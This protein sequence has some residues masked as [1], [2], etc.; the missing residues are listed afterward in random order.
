[1]L[2][3]SKLLFETNN[4]QKGR[5]DAT[6]LLEGGGNNKVLEKL[7]YNKSKNIKTTLFSIGMM[8]S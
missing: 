2:N 6:I 5:K 8:Q 1:M 7:R 3:V 4:Y